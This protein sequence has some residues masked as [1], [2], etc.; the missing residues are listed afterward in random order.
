MCIG[1]QDIPT[2]P[3]IKC[4]HDLEDQ[5]VLRN[6]AE[7]ALECLYSNDRRIRYGRLFVESKKFLLC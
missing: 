3:Y 5:N 4:F 7:N 1:F 6:S 2:V